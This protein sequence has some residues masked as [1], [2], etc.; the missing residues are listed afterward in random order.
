M[1]VVKRNAP[2]KNVASVPIRVL[3]TTKAVLLQGKRNKATK[4]AI[5]LYHT[6][7]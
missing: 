3:L 4:S 2:K 5:L 7:S 1:S 6:L